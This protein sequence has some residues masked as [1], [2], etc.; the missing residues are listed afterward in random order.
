MYKD[1]YQAG[2]ASYLEDCKATIKGS[3]DR[4]IGEARRLAEKAGQ[5]LP[6]QQQGDYWLGYHHGRA[7]AKTC[8]MKQVQ[9]LG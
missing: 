8:L 2:W 6:P 7:A 4:F 3:F 9:Q 5:S 1:G